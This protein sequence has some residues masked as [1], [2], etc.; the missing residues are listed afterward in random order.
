MFLY[1][2]NDSCLVYYFKLIE[3]HVIWRI[4]YTYLKATKRFP[5]RPVDTKTAVSTPHTINMVQAIPQSTSQYPL[6]ASSR[7]MY[8]SISHFLSEGSPINSQ[9]WVSQFFSHATLAQPHPVYIVMFLFFTKSNRVFV[10]PVQP[11][12]HGE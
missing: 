3:V 12:A 4:Q 1:H 7:L 11:A 8:S 6:T 10:G 5:T 9:G 2:K